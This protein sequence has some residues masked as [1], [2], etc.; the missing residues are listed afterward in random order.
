MSMEATL[1][2]VDVSTLDIYCSVGQKS[3]REHYLHLWENEDPTPYIANSLQKSVVIQELKNPNL[4]HYLIQMGED[5]VGIVKLVKN[6]G[7]DELSDDISLKA[8]KIYLLK[9][10]S[11]K[12]L[13]KKVLQLI[14]QKALALK[15]KVIWLDTMQ[16]GNPIQFYQ[17]NG[18]MIKRESELTLAGAKASEKAMH[19]LTKTL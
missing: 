10:Y 11:G 16:K 9:A 2:I 3:Y 19:I 15:K 8:E 14:E 5:I 1:Q 13:G 6:C 12:G 7:I 18:F 4:A 17:K